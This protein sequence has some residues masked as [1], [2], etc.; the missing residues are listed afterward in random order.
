[1]LL[2]YL[3]TFINVGY[4]GPLVVFGYFMIWA[5]IN[6]PLTRPI[7]KMIYALDRKEGDFRF[8]QFKN[9]LLTSK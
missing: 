7:I 9:N 1:M 8:A 6:G 3:K 4:T 2:N 5:L